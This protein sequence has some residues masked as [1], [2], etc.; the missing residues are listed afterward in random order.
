MVLVIAEI[1]VNHNG[2]YDTCIALVDAAIACGADVAKFQLFNPKLVDSSIGWLALDHS[3]I[4]ALDNYCRGKIK[5]A[6]TA[7]DVESLKW[8]L[9]NTDMHFVKIS[10]GKWN[11]DKMLKIAYNSRKM[12]IQS[13]S[14]GNADRLNTRWHYL[15]VV[16]EYPTPPNR[17]NLKRVTNK[18]CSGFSDHSGDIF[19]PLAAV[20]MGA[21]IIE[22]HITMD[23][24]QDGPDHL[25]SLEP[26][27]FKEMVRGI[28]AIEQGLC[29]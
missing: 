2:D 9:A 6:C 14:Q 13:I 11:D 5:F 29:K 21:E 1:G 27:K 20:A 26:H 18:W 16:P 28:R 10:S 15:H 24:G 25:A 3:E 17:A 4:R 7:F 8:L 22:C 12:V 23:K 19:M